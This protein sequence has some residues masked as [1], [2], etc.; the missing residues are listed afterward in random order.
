MVQECIC[1]VQGWVL[2]DIH[3]VVSKLIIS[4]PQTGQPCNLCCGKLLH[5]W[6]L[7]DIIYYVI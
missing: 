4:L 5:W 1:M 6:W 2:S 7:Y 3:E